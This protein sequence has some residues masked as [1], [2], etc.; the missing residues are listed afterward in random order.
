[1]DDLWSLIRN[2]NF[3]LVSPIYLP[4]PLRHLLHDIKYTTLGGLQENDPGLSIDVVPGSERHGQV[5][6]KLHIWHL[7]SS[8]LEFPCIVVVELLTLLWI[9]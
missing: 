2:R 3:V 7:L 5:S 8:I 1:M 9:K 6:I 4:S